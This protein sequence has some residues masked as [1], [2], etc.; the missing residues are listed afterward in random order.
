M[1]F[2]RSY[3]PLINLVLIHAVNFVFV[4]SQQPL[5]EFQQNFI[6]GFI[7]CDWV[8]MYFLFDRTLTE[9]YVASSSDTPA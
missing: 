9:N 5:T 8:I 1:N 6:E 7:P 2:S 4:N 3:W